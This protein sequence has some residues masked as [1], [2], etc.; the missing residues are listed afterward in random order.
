MSTRAVQDALDV[1][2][3]IS[4]THLPSNETVS[5]SAYL[6]KFSDNYSQE[7]SSESVYGRMD[8]IYLYKNTKR[9]M[10]IAI[11]IPSEDT[12]EG[13]LNFRKISK[14]I[15]FSYPV[16]QRSKFNPT[17]T[18]DVTTIIGQ[19][20]PASIIT[21]NALLLSTPPILG[22]KFANL[23]RSNN[24]SGKLICKMDSVSYETDTESGYFSKNGNLYSMIY[25]LDLNLD[26]MHT[27][28]LGWEKGDNDRI[29]PRTRNFP[30]GV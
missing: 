1:N 9:K 16:Y 12:A 27:D 28:A 5:F 14:L 23:A 29:V 7:W 15:K 13:E 11:D 3:S 17:T 25:K 4:I 30:Y 2:F 20:T 18:Q 26:I 6:T 22:V 24:Q 8:P 21:G 10:S 19:S